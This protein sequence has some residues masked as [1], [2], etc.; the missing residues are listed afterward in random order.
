MH[1]IGQRDFLEMMATGKAHAQTRR[2]RGLAVGHHPSWT[3]KHG[4][5]D[6]AFCTFAVL[7]AEYRSRFADVREGFRFDL[8]GSQWEGL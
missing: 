2:N 7:R 5:Y 4:N 8:F 3:H 1:R 6:P